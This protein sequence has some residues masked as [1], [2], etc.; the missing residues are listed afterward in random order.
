MI[1]SNTFMILAFVNN[2]QVDDLRHSVE[3]L[4]GRLP[5]RAI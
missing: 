3:P 4:P 2:N 5:V 1:Y